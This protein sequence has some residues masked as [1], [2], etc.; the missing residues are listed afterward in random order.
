MNYF[1]VRLNRYLVDIEYTN[2]QPKEELIVNKS[3][4][5]LTDLLN[6]VFDIYGKN[7]S[8]RGEFWSTWEFLNS[9]VLVAKKK[10]NPKEVEPFSLEL[11]RLVR[12]F[13]KTNN[14]RIL[15]RMTQSSACSMLKDITRITV[16]WHDGDDN[17]SGKVFSCLEKA[18]EFFLEKSKYAP[19]PNGYENWK[20]VLHL[21]DGDQLL[22]F[23][24]K[25]TPNS[26]LYEHIVAYLMSNLTI[27][28][29]QEGKEMKEIVEKK[30]MAMAKCPDCGNKYVKQTGYCMS[31]KKKIKDPNAKTNKK[32]DDKKKKES[33]DLAMS[34][35]TEGKFPN[36]TKY[37]MVINSPSKR[38]AFDLVKVEKGISE[39]IS[40]FD[41]RKEAEF[42]GKQWNMPVYFQDG[43]KLSEDVNWSMNIGDEDDYLDDTYDDFNFDDVSDLLRD[44]DG[45]DDVEAT[46]LVVDSDQRGLY[47]ILG[48]QGEVIKLGVNKNNVSD[49]ANDYMNRT[50]D[51]NEIYYLGEYGLDVW[52]E[53]LDSIEEAV[54]RI[55]L[56]GINVELLGFGKDQNGNSIV[57]LQMFGENRAFSIQ[58][59]GTLSETH[60]LVWKKKLKEL[61][62]LDLENIS[63][64]VGDYIEKYLPN[65]KFIRFSK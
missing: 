17:Y 53:S 16:D 5:S 35:I 46:I 57:K 41:D 42:V 12:Q 62:D 6:N 14:T 7:L 33:L 56:P 49:V 13:E 32:K 25:L 28:E 64:E 20:L 48:G 11:K 61:T 23:V 52:K 31:C 63:K 9:I 47:D 19:F 4:L 26:H 15:E 27:L 60:D 22:G 36:G 44:T 40:T 2:E 55:T 30:K 58:T 21:R 24:Y 10:F 29:K 38:N 54:S 39:Y 43:T 34:F 59:N 3:F 65:K 50:G 8:K 18:N 51:Y 37:L 1:L 45:L